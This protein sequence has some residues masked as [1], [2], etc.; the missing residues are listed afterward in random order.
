MDDKEKDDFSIE[1]DSTSLEELEKNFQAMISGLIT[2]HAFEGFRGQY[3]AIYNAF[4]ESQKNNKLLV[5]KCRELN[6]EILANATKINTVLKYSEDDQRTIQGLKFEFEK[7]WKMVELSQDREQKSKDV[8]DT[9]KAETNRLNKIV[10]QGGALAFQNDTSLDTVQTEIKA[11]KQEIIIQKDQIKQ[12]SHDLDQLT[13]EKAQFESTTFKLKDEKNGLEKDIDEA[14]SQTKELEKSLNDTMTEMTQTKSVIVG[15]RSDSSE[16]KD[17]KQNKKT[18][19]SNRSSDLAAVI[20]EKSV[21]EA[22][23]QNQI[24]AVD[25]ARGILE[26][27]KATADKSQQRCTRIQNK[28]DKIDAELEEISVHGKKVNSEIEV[29]RADYENETTKRNAVAQELFAARKRLNELRS[30]LHIKQHKLLASESENELRRHDISISQQRVIVEKS[31]VVQEKKKT[32]DIDSKVNGIYNEMLTHKI[33]ISKHDI[34]VQSL[35]KEIEQ[36]IDETAQTITN[37]EQLKV[38]IEENN[39]AAQENHLIINTINEKIQHQIATSDL[40]SE[41]RNVLKRKLEEIKHEF[42]S[43]VDENATVDKDIKDTKQLIKEKDTECLQTHIKR[44]ELLE[45]IDNEQKEKEQLEKKFKETNIEIT[46]LENMKM[47]TRYLLEVAE[48]DIIK[49]KTTIKG[50]DTEFKLLQNRVHEK[51]YETEILREKINLISGH[52]NATA[53]TYDKKVKSVEDLKKELMFEVSKKKQLLGRCKHEKFLR[54]EMMN[55]EKGLIFQQCRAKALEEEL[56]TPMNVHR[57]RFLES[58]NPEMMNLIK[59]SQSLRNTLMLKLTRMDRLKQQKAKAEEDVKLSRRRLGSRNTQESEQEIKELQYQLEQQNEQ[60][61]EIMAE[62]SSKEPTVE[63]RKKNA[64]EVREEL[65]NTKRSFF[66]EKKKVNSIRAS[67]MVKKP[68]NETEQ[69]FI[70]GGF[71]VSQANTTSQSIS[72]LDSKMLGAIVIPKVTNS[73]P[74][75]INPKGWNPSRTPLRPFLPTV[76][77]LSNA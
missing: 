58:S 43:S 73:K 17:Q 10:E 18:D 39:Q 14:E 34:V 65:S 32:E 72:S 42:D 24:A 37:T 74:Q 35:K 33:D 4:L 23:L 36:F 30:D 75:K 55:L 15:R 54:T 45:A 51:H 60:L 26:K 28:I 40:L 25:V 77:E 12:L 5:E 47:R 61:K 9:L 62:I 38:L 7:A 68:I 48:K 6:H 21:E 44:A 11:L 1:D 71:S 13:T 69:K 19:I 56:E 67:S 3:E 49:M 50:Y 46:T 16:L 2:E 41:Q 52:L 76:S 57:W 8:I 22:S 31:N 27:R 29:N 66:A 59:M 70:G 63:L 64:E 53:S 20:R